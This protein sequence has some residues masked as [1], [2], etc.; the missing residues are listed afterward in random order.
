MIISKQSHAAL[1]PPWMWTSNQNKSY[2]SIR[3]H[4]IDDNWCIQKRIINF[5]HLEGRHTGTKLSETFT[6]LMLKWN[7]DKKLFALTLDNAAANELATKD[8]VAD[9]KATRTSSLVC[10][11]IFFHVSVLVTF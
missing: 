5:V 6:E 8:I 11:G 10:D 2:M 9:I 7:V 3:V 1:V 4:W